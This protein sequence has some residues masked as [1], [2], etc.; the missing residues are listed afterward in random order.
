MTSAGTPPAPKRPRLSPELTTHP[1]AS[2]SPDHTEPKYLTLLSLAATTSQ[3]HVLNTLTTLATSFGFKTNISARNFRPASQFHHIVGS[4]YHGRLL[5]FLFGDLGFSL[6]QVQTAL[7]MISFPAPGETPAV[8]AES[9]IAL[10]TPENQG[11]RKTFF[12]WNADQ[13]PS[14]Y[15]DDGRWGGRVWESSDE[16]RGCL[17]RMMR[18][19]GGEKGEEHGRVLRDVEGWIAGV[20]GGAEVR[21]VVSVGGGWGGGGGGGGGGVWGG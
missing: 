10:R 20:G 15:A 21:M 18:A 19:S 16:Q 14:E 6:G 9:V 5:A 8:V 7:R 11:A 12:Y 1:S 4:G 13:N 2:P 3:T 17:V